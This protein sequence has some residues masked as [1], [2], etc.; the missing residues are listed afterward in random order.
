MGDRSGDASLLR[1]AELAERV[2]RAAAAARASGALVPIDTRVRRIDDAGIPF[3]VRVSVNVARKQAAAAGPD[4]PFAPPYE[5]DLHVGDLS[6]THVVLLNKFNVLDGHI[7]LVTRDYEEQTRML[8]VAD[9]EAL[10]LGL[11]GIDGLAFYNGGPEAGASQA[12][13]HLQVV[14]LPLAPDGPALPFADPLE[15]CALDAHGVGRVGAFP[16]RHAV[17]AL[18]PEWL[19]DPAAHAD[20]AAAALAAL[21]RAVG[22]EPGDGP[23]PVA[24]NLLATRRWMWLV[25]RRRECAQGIS[26]NALGFAGALLAPDEAACERLCRAGPMHVLS[27]TAERP[28]GSD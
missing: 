18:R 28:A 9:C 24:Y 20:A 27:A 3:V 14:P 8:S 16:F 2:R 13:K 26:V 1:P 4:D 10:L 5:N 11:A 12:H 17:C 7:L 6:P 15:R 19:D 22:R 21:W 25:P 23:Q